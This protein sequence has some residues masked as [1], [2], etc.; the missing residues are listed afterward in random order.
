MGGVSPPPSTAGHAQLA[1]VGAVVTLDAGGTVAE[2]LAV[3]DGRIV[4]V[5]DRAGLGGHV[6]PGTE[7]IEL[8]GGAVIPGINDSHL[9]GV[10]LGAGMPPRK[11]DLSY[12]TVRSIGEVVERVRAATASTPPGTWI[13]GTGWNRAFLDECRSDPERLPTRWDL[14]AASTDHPVLLDGSSGHS[15]WV[16]SKALELAGIDRASE[17]PAGSMIVKDS[18]TGEPTGLLHEPG[19]QGLVQAIVPPLTRERRRDS[20]R[21][22]QRLLA[23]LGITSYTEPALGPGGDTFLGGAAAAEGIDVYAEL[24]RAGESL[25]RINVLLLFGEPDGISG[26]E[27]VR[28]GLA[29]YDRP[30]DVDPAWLRI[31]GVKI[32]ADGVPP[33]KTAW[34][35]EEYEGGGRGSL[36]VRGA[37]DA[38]RVS[39]LRA[40]VAAGH[41]AGWQV[42]VHAAGDAAIDAVVAAFVAAMDASPRPD[43]RHYVIHG[44]LLSPGTRALIARYGI[45]VN[46]QPLI[47][48]QL[49]EALALVVGRRRAE[50]QFP[51]RSLLDDGSAVCLSSDAP[52]TSPDWRR[53]VAAAVERVSLVS[54][55]VSSPEQRITVA[56]AL[57]AYTATPAWQDR[58]EDWKGTLEPGK[59]ADLCV[60]GA[61]PLAT[62]AADLPDVPVLRTVV[63]G[64][65]VFA[66]A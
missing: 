62:P 55:R 16:N 59:V 45:G 13:V 17:S 1:F 22:A 44:D 65:T 37:D 39:E 43:P 29:S 58:A 5:G 60:L 2:A 9:H 41:E 6:G 54:G 30:E 7:L 4:Y 33:S 24:A 47:H 31:A 56:Q 20:I 57:R 52:I 49:V 11:L 66:A 32:F 19:A 21:D 63:G 28:T 35:N 36:V 61:N 53:G 23:S 64:R 15:T 34:M 18:G 50:S 25:A 40:M 48:T 27:D 38:E 14:D 10:L 8:A 42:G 3:S 26:A 46:A 12:P 51:L